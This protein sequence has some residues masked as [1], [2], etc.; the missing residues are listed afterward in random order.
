M[1]SRLP[2]TSNEE[3]RV[4]AVL[5]QFSSR[6]RTFV[7]LS[8]NTGYRVSEILSLSVGQVWNDFGPATEVTVSRRDLKGGRGA[9]QRRVRSRSIPLNA[10]ARAAIHAH[11]VSLSKAGTALHPSGPLFPSLR[12]G[13]ALGRWQANRIVHRVTAAAGLPRQGRYG[14]HTLRK[15]YCRKL[16]AAS[17]HDINLTRAAMGHASI[18]TTQKYLEV[19][20][21]RVR[22]LVLAI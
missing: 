15:T 18:A 5:P 9:R 17:R 1:P 6:D 2:L 16:Y 21:D 12:K 13:R 8:L 14:T 19:D 22:D 10:A 7:L 20:E 11:I 4:V 3:A